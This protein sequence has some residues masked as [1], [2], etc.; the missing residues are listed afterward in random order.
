M[1][2]VYV[3][4]GENKFLKNKQ[5]DEL[6]KSI[7]SKEI[8]F[9]NYETYQAQE[10]DF[11]LL[12]ESLKSL[13]LIGKKLIFIKEADRFSSQ[14][15]EGILTLTAKNKFVD[16]ILDSDKKNFSKQIPFSY[17]V[18]IKIF[19]K[20]YPD[21]IP[22]WIIKRAKEKRLEISKDAVLLLAENV[23]DDLETLDSTLD[24]LLNFVDKK[25]RVE[26]EDVEKLVGVNVGENVFGIV[27]AVA[28][29]DIKQALKLTSSILKKEGE[30]HRVLALVAWHFSRLLIAKKISLCYEGQNVRKKIQESLS[31]RDFLV[32]KFMK[33]L[34]NFTFSQLESSLKEL[35]KAD[36]EIKSK[37][38]NP[39]YILEIALIKLCRL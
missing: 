14:E 27:D 21:K 34:N 36:I 3:L 13:T 31:L 30:H 7:L 15:L 24:V 19:D 29:K 32:Q 37:P 25:R 4:C 1:A 28:Q 10:D 26:K 6:K 11:N 18:N 39:L 12:K 23:G 2:S 8:S 9:L 20:I 17:K 22:A 5:I 33:Q 35:L 16:L 38:I